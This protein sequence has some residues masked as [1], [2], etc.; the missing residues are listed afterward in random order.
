M[1]KM[2]RQ[3]VLT[4]QRALTL[5]RQ[6]QYTRSAYVLAPLSQYNPVAQFLLGTMYVDGKGVKKDSARGVKFLTASAARG[7]REAN[8]ILA[9][10]YST[11][12]GV[13]RD[14]KKAY[15]L[16][17]MDDSPLSL[18]L[19]GMFLE[20][21]LGAA[22]NFPEAFLCYSRAAARGSADGKAC[23]AEYLYLGKEGVPQ[24]TQLARR[25]FEESAQKGNPKAQFYLAEI[26][27]RGELVPK[28]LRKARAYLASAELTILQS[29]KNKGP[30]IVM[31]GDASVFIRRIKSIVASAEQ[32]EA[33]ATP[34]G[35]AADQ[36]ETKQGGD[37]TT[38]ATQPAQTATDKDGSEPPPLGASGN[39]A[40]QAA[41]SAI[42]TP[43]PESSTTNTSAQNTEN[44]VDGDSK[45]R[46]EA[47]K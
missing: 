33:A 15:E 42:S 24:N 35:V 19:R 11:G 30:S 13:P 4:L 21:G 38:T 20:N 28:D 12:Q 25:Y 18:C 31:V 8:S 9:L 7:F 26:Y 23:A 41:R 46:N 5:Q 40:A 39:P 37:D 6:G 47:T 36:T 29:Q 16:A 44:K 34:A 43:P 27:A 14:F 17:S 1:Q 22:K 32:A 45:I 10:L 2:S 3:E